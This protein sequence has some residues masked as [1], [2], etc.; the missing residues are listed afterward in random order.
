MEINLRWVTFNH[1]LAA[2][3]QFKC[4][5]KSK[6]CENTPLSSNVLYELVFGIIEK[7]ITST[8]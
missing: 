4:Y 1:L 2:R 8:V 5:F 6:L 3:E 7:P